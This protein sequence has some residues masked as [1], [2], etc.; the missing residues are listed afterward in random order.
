MVALAVVAGVGTCAVLGLVYVRFFM[1]VPGTVEVLERQLTKQDAVPAGQDEGGDARIRDS[2]FLATY[3]SMT[4]YAA[5]GLVPGVA[6]LVGTYPWAD[7]FGYWEACND[8]G[9]GRDVLVDVA[10]PDDRGVL[11]VPDQF[12]HTPLERD[13]WV[14]L[15]RNLLIQPLDA[16]QRPTQPLTH[17]AGY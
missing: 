1:A 16:A 13:G 4:Y 2:R 9:D 15:H 5:P 12:D 3:E 17:A 7:E 10:D 11:F 6:C 14:T 8:I